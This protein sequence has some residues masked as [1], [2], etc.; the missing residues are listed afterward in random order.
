MAKAAR[1]VGGRRRSVFAL[2]LRPHG[3]RPGAQLGRLIPRQGHEILM[4]GAF[5]R[6]FHFGV[7]LP[8]TS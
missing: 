1:P 2:E 5:G 3:L 8:M 6:L 4:T 7:G